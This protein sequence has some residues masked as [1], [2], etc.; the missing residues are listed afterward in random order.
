MSYGDHF[1]FEEIVKLRKQRL[2]T[3]RAVGKGPTTLFYIPRAKFLEFNQQNDI[4]Q[5]I[6]AC[7]SY[8][9]YEDL[10]RKQ[11]EE[12]QFKKKEVDA[13]LIALNVKDQPINQRSL[14]AS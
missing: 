4:K 3:A 14:E 13:F 2:T 8:T 9:D 6:T 12:L 1:G 10:G 7:E 11:L 5:L